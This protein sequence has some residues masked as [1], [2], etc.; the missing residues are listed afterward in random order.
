MRYRL[1][2]YKTSISPFNDYTMNAIAGAIS[3]NDINQWRGNYVAEDLLHFD[4]D[5]IISCIKKELADE[6]GQGCKCTPVVKY[7]PKG[8]RQ[9]PYL[10]V[11][12][13]YAVAASVLPRLHMIAA[14]N[15]LA[16][17]DAEMDR[18]FLQ[19]LVPRSH[20]TMRNRQLQLHQAIRSSL[21]SHCRI[22]CLEHQTG[23]QNEHS[24]YA[25]C[26]R[27]NS[28]MTFAE[29]NE[30]FFHCLKNSLQKGET[31]VCE[32][33][34][35]RIEREDDYSITYVLEGYAK[36]PC[37][38]GYAEDGL[39]KTAPLRRM[40]IDLIMRW[41]EGCTATEKEDIQSRMR[42]YEMVAAYPNPAQRLAESVKITKWQRKQLFGIRY[43]SIGTFGAEVIFHFSPDEG[44]RDHQAIS[45]L[46]IDEESASF[47]LAFIYDVYPMIFDEYYDT[48]TIPLYMWEEILE[49]LK[50]AREQIIRDPF[51]PALQPYYERIDLYVLLDR[52]RPVNR[53]TINETNRAQ[54]VYEHRYQIAAF[55][56]V[57]LKWADAQ[58]K[59]YNPYN[60]NRAFLIVG[61]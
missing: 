26:L 52:S 58:R 24:S 17:Y 27:K 2:L 46:K 48:S 6:S 51:D 41:M 55:F 18:T 57:F 43:S 19:D 60:G 13:S 11:S 61:P 38:E 49:R 29:E 14:E 56:D 30:R 39:P 3:R 10:Y 34:C 53:F 50:K 9:V 44:Y 1:Y 54:F 4:T 31:L 42:F 47:L 32:H 15:G 16:L 37:H 35:Y 28:R 21:Q 40:G 12:T 8:F 25:V 45:V 22:Y 7:P 20:I 23:R 5:T 36:H 59:Y 33:Q